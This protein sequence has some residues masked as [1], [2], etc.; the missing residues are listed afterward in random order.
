MW[1]TGDRILAARAG[2]PYLYPAT[3]LEDVSGTMHVA[4]D[5][6]SE[7]RV[8]SAA[9][10]KLEFAAGDRVEVRLPAGKTYSPATVQRCEAGKVCVTHADGEQEWTSPG[11]VRVQAGAPRAAPVPPLT[12]HSWVVGDRVL[13]RWGGDGLW[14]PGT[15]QGLDG[16]QLQIAFDDGDRELMLPDR[17]AML[18][19]PE[20]TR[21]QGRWKGGPQFYAGR[22]AARDGE[23]VQIKYDDGDEEWTTVSFVRLRLGAAARNWSKGDRVLA[24]WAND[25]LW[26]P[27]T[28]AEGGAGTITVHYDD[29]GQGPVA[30]EDAEPLDLRAGDRVYARW[31]NGQEYFPGRIT[32]ISG[33]RVHVVYDDGDKEWTTLAAVGVLPQELQ[34]SRARR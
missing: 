12:P 17:V 10:R 11:M 3:V 2:E 26:Y 30:A 22:V 24:K 32:E 5:D 14:Y 29:G 33:A 21:V 18:D 25:N 8:P 34:Q 13:A 4:F 23:K 1:R 20:G 27:G 15:V 7:A 9:V 28:V 16:R 19:L 31:Q 6:G